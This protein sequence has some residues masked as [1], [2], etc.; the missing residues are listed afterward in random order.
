MT[1]RRLDPDDPRLRAPD[2]PHGEMKGYRKGCS[3]PPCRRA[4]AASTAQRK[5]RLTGAP[6][7]PQGSEVNPPEMRA[8]LTRLLRAGTAEAVAHAAGIHPQIV[9]TLV[10]DP[11][12]RVRECTAER[13]LATRPDQVRSLRGRLPVGPCRR[14]VQWLLEQ[15]PD[16][17]TDTI[18]RALSCAAGGR[19][20]GTQLR[21]ICDGTRRY[22]HP[23]TVL[24]I[25]RLTPDDVR[26]HVMFV[27][28]ARTRQQIRSLQAQ[29]W[30]LAELAHRLGYSVTR[31][32]PFLYKSGPVTADLAARVEA[33]YQAI[34]DSYGDSPLSGRRA[35]AL[36][37]HPAICYDD[38]GR[39]IPD[40]VR[41]DLADAR[42]AHDEAEATKHRTWLRI[43]GLAITGLSNAEVARLVKVDRKEVERCKSRRADAH[44]IGLA[45]SDHPRRDEL[46]ALVIDAVA[47]IELDQATDMCDAPD[48]DYTDRW[49][50]LHTQACLLA[51]AEATQAHE[52]A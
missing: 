5:T 46:H 41:D 35:R 45:W 15:V 26:P 33:I 31:T 44:G 10:A 6:H 32:L 37:Y 20:F 12:K 49:T 52:A 47:G 30:P 50:M 7:N 18:G 39:L 23:E 42:S 17:N 34:G 25:M 24:T 21:R 13:I 38:D 19:D 40:V 4:N 11:H 2:F 3:C 29:D 9:R 28:G 1:R 48:L 43:V 16:A 8:H 36:G 51:P 22:L 27:D 14:H